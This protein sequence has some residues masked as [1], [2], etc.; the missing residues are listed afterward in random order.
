MIDYYRE[1]KLPPYSPVADIKPRLESLDERKRQNAE[2]ILLSPLKKKVY[3][4]YLRQ[5][6]KIGKMRVATGL[7]S[8]GSW[9]IHGYVYTPTTNTLIEK[10]I[11]GVQLFVE[12]GIHHLIRLLTAIQKQVSSTNEK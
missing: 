5:L 3:D 9:Q 12:K 7:I 4:N 6:I 2:Y 11:H 8:V 1:L 10:F